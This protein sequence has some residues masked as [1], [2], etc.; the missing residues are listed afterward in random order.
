MIEGLD[1]AA[2]F[3]PRREPDTPKDTIR[4]TTIIVKNFFT[5]FPFQPVI[6]QD[7]LK[8]LNHFS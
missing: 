7:A 6:S 1:A 2:E 3:S 5:F 4:N 8:V